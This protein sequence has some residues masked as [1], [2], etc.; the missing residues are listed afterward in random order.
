MSTI[1]DKLGPTAA[2]IISFAKNTSKCNSCNGLLL[3]AN[4]INVFKS[5]VVT[6]FD[7]FEKLMIVFTFKY[8]V[9]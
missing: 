1:V 2:V 8:K 7:K 3:V 4:A 9:L 5:R 6:S